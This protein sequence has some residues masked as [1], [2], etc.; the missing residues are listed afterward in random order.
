MYHDNN[1]HCGI[2]KVIQKI[3]NDYWFLSMR[4]QTQ[5]YVDN[6]LICFIANASINTKEGKLQ[7]IPKLPMHTYRSF[8]SIDGI[9]QWT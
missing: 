4:E 8:W 1:A 2:E 3:R 9:Y 6:C 5:S 7:E